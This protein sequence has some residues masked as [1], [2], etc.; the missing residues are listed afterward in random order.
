MESRVVGEQKLVFT[1]GR[2]DLLRKNGEKTE[3]YF[4]FKKNK[5]MA[6]DRILFKD[7][8]IGELIE[9]REFYEIIIDSEFLEPNNKLSDKIQSNTITLKLH[10]ATIEGNE[11]NIK[12]ETK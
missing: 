10:E 4:D 3:I 7:T 2:G 11:I 1:I 6:N 9:R 8:P 5:V 12:E